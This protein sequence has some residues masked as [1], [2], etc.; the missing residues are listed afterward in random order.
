MIIFNRCQ[1]KICFVVLFSAFFGSIFC[2]PLAASDFCLPF[3]GK[4]MSEINGIYDAY[5]HW[6]SNAG[7]RIPA[8]QG[9]YSTIKNSNNVLQNVSKTE[10]RGTITGSGSRGWDC[11]P[12]GSFSIVIGYTLEWTA[13]NWN[14]N[15][16]AL[17][18]DVTVNF[19]F[20]DKWD[21]EKNPEYSKWK[22][23]Y[24][25]KLPGFVAGH[26]TPFIIYGNLENKVKISL[27]Q[28]Q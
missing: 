26:G 19:T 27:I 15:Q 10:S 28:R 17:N 9:L 24:R 6:R 21:F 14:I 25:E 5:C 20:S 4:S 8:G 13:T 11:Y 2:K 12:L 1:R 22:N 16:R 3:K 18:G 23:L 7:G